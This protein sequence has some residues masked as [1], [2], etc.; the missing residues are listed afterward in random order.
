MIDTA[1]LRKKTK[2]RDVLSEGMIC[3]GKELG[4]NNEHDGI[5]IL[6]NNLK[7]G[8]EVNRALSL[9]ESIFDFD[10]IYGIL[11]RNK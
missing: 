4:I 7:V 5:M 3:S 11:H 8:E 2:I 10:M 6:N 1:G 9:S